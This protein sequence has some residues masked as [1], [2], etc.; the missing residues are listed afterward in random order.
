MKYEMNYEMK[1][2]FVSEFIDDCDCDSD[3]V[4]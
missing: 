4:V 3:M 2:N 1:M